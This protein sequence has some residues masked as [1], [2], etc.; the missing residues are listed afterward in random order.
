MRAGS[1]EAR[2]IGAEHPPQVGVGQDQGVIEAFASPAAEK[3]LHDGVRAGRLD[4]T[5]KLKC[6]ARV[7]G[8]LS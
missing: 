5:V 7:L 4:E 6:A 3:A 8:R 1:S 2:D